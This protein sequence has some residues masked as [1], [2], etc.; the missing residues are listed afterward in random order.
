MPGNIVDATEHLIMRHNPQWKMNGGSGLH[1][2]TLADVAVAG[3]TELETFSFDLDVP[4]TH[5]AWRGRIRASAGVAA[6]LPPAKVAEFDDDLAR[7]LKREYPHD[8]LSVLH[9]VWVLTARNS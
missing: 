5:E 7:L 1:P 4:Y 9:R 3:F 8:P 6:S 2:R